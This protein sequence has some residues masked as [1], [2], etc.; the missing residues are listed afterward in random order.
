VSLRPQTRSLKQQQ[1]YDT[2]QIPYWD[3]ISQAYPSIKVRMAFRGAV[4]GD[5][6][7]HCHILDHEVLGMMAIIRVKPKN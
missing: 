2:F 3:G 6:V 4:I 5:F 1:F 7:Y